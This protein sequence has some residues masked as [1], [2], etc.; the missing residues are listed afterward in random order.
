TLGHGAQP[1]AIGGVL[2]VLPAGAQ[3]KLEAPTREVGQRGGLADKHGRVAEGHGRDQ[4]AELEARRL[5]RQPAERGPAFERVSIRTRGV[6]EVVGQ[7]EADEAG[8][9]DGADDALQAIPVEAV[10]ALDHQRDFHGVY[11]RYARGG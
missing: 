5:S 9:L 1:E 4:R 6:G 8:V 10:L 3:A 2:A 11:L 7:V